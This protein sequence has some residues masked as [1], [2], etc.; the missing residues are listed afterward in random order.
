MRSRTPV[1]A[2]TWALVAAVLVFLLLGA[3]WVATRVSA[4][5]PAD[6]PVELV[7]GPADPPCWV[8]GQVGDA[9]DGPC[10][11][12]ADFRGGVLRRGSVDSTA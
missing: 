4:P 3:G 7:T 11:D 6:G 10:I 5:P 2:R 1:S 12:P 8:V 9:E